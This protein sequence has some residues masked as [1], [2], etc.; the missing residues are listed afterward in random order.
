MNLVAR[1]A[2][3]DGRSPPMAEPGRQDNKDAEE[4]GKPV[5]LDK[6]RPAGQ[7]SDREQHEGGQQMPGREQQQPGKEQPPAK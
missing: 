2:A 7:Q 1:N 5:Q 3:R 4:S 6:E